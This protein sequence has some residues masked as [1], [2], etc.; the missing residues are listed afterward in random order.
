MINLIPNLTVQGNLKQIRL[1]IG[2]AELQ[3]AKQVSIM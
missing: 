1:F 2:S 3:E